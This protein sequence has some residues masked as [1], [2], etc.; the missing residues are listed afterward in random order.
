MKRASST[1]TRTFRKRPKNV[2]SLNAFGHSLSTLSTTP[3]VI[4]RTGNLSA[5]G[6]RAAVELILLSSHVMQPDAL[7]GSS[8]LPDDDEDWL[9]LH[10]PSDFAADD[11][12]VGTGGGSRT[13]RRKWYA[14]TDDNLAHWVHNHRDSY[15]RVLTTREGPMNQEG[16]CSCGQP[17]A[18]RCVE[19]FG[20]EMTC[21]GCM[22]EQHKL[23]PLC[24]IERWNGAFFSKRELRDL[25]LRVQLSHCDNTPCSR[26]QPGRHKFVVVAPNGFHHVA[27]DFCECRLS[28]SQARW[29]QLLAHGWY[30][31]TPDAPRS[32]ITISTLK[33]FHA[34]SLQ[35]KTTA[36]HFF[37]ALAKIT[38]N[39]GSKGFKHRYQ[40]LLCVVRQW[41]NLRALKR[42]GM[43]NNADRSTSETQPGELAVECI[44]C[45]KAGVNLPEKWEDVPAD[46][47]FLYAIFLAIDACFRLKRKKISSWWSGPS[48]Q[49]GW[50]Y[51]VPSQAYAEFVKGLADQNEM[52]TC[53][54]LAA[55]D[56]ANTKYAQGYAATGCGMVTCG[57]H[58]VVCKNGVGDLQKGEKYGNMD[59]IVA[60][61]WR[62]LCTLLFFL[63]SYDIM[64]QWSKSLG[65]RLLQ[66][67]PPA[68]RF[69]IARYFV[70]FVIP[71]L[72]ILGHLRLCQELYS[73]LFTLGAAQSDMEGIERIWSSSG[74]MGASTREMGPGSRQDTLDDFWHYWN[75]GKVVGMGETLRKRLRKA[76]N[77][78]SRQIA[79][80]EE[81]NQ[82]QE[83]QISAWKEA[84]SHFHLFRPT[85]ADVAVYVGPTLRDIELE[86]A[87]EEQERE[88]TSTT[89]PA[90]SE[91]TMTEY[92]I[93][94]L[95]IEGQQ[96]QLVAD[97]LAHRSPTTKQLTDFV[98][99][100]TRMSCEIKKLQSLQRKYLP[101]A[102]QRLAMSEDPTAQPEA[103]R[104]PLLLPSALSPA[105]RTPPLSV[106]GLAAAEA[107]LRDAQCSE[108]LDHIWYGL[109]IKKRLHTYKARNAR[110]QHQ[111][112]RS[113]G[114][115]DAH[116]RKIDVSAA[117]YRHARRARIALDDVAGVSVW[118]L[119]EA[120]DL[121]MMEDEEEAKKRKQRAMKG[122]RKEAEQENEYGEVRGVPGLGE[123]T[124]L[125]SWIWQSVGRAGGVVGEELY[126]GVKV[127]WCKAYAC[128]KRWWEEVLLVQ[129]EM[130][131]CLKTLEWQA[132]VLDK[133]A[134]AEHYNG[135]VTYGPTHLVGARAHAARQ[136]AVRRTLTTRFRRLWGNLTNCVEGEREVA[137][138]ESSR[139]EEEDDMR[140]DED[141]G[142]D[143]EEAGGAPSACGAQEGGTEPAPDTGRGMTREEIAAR[144]AEMDELLALQSTSLTDYDDI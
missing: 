18:Y 37:H 4:A 5:D 95:E 139:A 35:G 58:E 46:K 9:D 70:K 33:L 29:E 32:A 105:Q 120:V 57:R 8:S 60:S 10:H 94:G 109:I 11:K 45:P 30:P 48:I 59:Y 26:A 128:V 142:S 96:R 73:L 91:E 42:G 100:P 143:D 93:L 52:S 67:L 40:V 43:G 119:L 102:L 118:R 53:T 137:S 39:T 50:A 20:G 138:S 6:R 44:A 117:T 17:S 103:E 49:D 28:G 124:R 133:R 87:R 22:V 12:A 34:V 104:V 92:L 7:A 101:G 112:T 36:Y 108:S 63:L 77:K 127:E 113:R 56:H 123:N 107:R 68:L 21:R 25:G 132:Q 99:R 85:Q 115:L 82:E 84:A 54:G 13:R 114:V 116:Q 90:T 74:L 136:A 81:F 69:E 130:V 80:L 64:C 72:H 122:K 83:D 76:T 14:A 16:I 2:F 141:R 24:R 125:I 3:S 89:V 131:R 1:P 65:E 15:L 111:N 129:E 140:E 19:C 61:A 23:R 71:K 98:T 62:H 106:P 144:R 88:R 97:L 78:L 126:K 110:H 38:D 47:R 31:L 55:L 134:T 66:R 41:R 121:R 27:V 79:G 51:F 75:W 135:K 86:L